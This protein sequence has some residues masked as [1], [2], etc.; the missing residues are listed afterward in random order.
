MRYFL[1]DQKGHSSL[2][3]LLLLMS[4]SLLFIASSRVVKEGIFLGS[5]MRKELSVRAEMNIMAK[6]VCLLLE[7]DETPESQ[8]LMDPV[9]DYME[10]P[11][12]GVQWELKDL[13][14]RL[15][16]N[17]MRLKLF[18]VTDLGNLITS[19]ESI[20]QL[21]QRRMD[22][23]IGTSL[24]EDWTETFGEENIERF[25]TYYSLAN[26]NVTQ[27]DRLEEI[28][29]K[30]LGDGGASA[31]RSRIQDGL[32]EFR[33]WNEEDLDVVLGMEGEELQPLV[34]VDAQ[35]NVHWID[36]FLLEALL[37]YP[38]REEPLADPHSIA[39]SIL[40][41]RDQQ[42]LDAEQLKGI[43]GP[44]EKQMRVLEY[45]GTATY[46]WE[47][48]IEKENVLGTWVIFLYKGETQIVKRSFQRSPESSSL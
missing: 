34:G 24:E 41:L 32:R 46:F 7:E 11:P 4:F 42:E 29:R 33:L 23:G 25:F 38:Y 36:P 22:K 3:V 26:I 37:S 45:L 13:S 30:R 35:M 28:Y 48:S 19:G 18:K 47:L 6:E 5:R 10:N 12:E 15:N 27:E 14:S 40:S 2:T 16:P 17:W 39:L 9:W 20:E 21:D 43:I 31:F 1:K 8:S 44:N